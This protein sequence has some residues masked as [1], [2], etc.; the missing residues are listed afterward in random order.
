MGGRRRIMRGLGMCCRARRS[1]PAQYAGDRI[2]GYHLVPRWGTGRGGTPRQGRDDGSRWWNHR[3]GRRGEGG[4]TLCE[5]SG[6]VIGHVGD[7]PPNTPGIASPATIRC[8]C[9]AQEEVARPGRG[10]MMVAGGGTTG[11]GGEGRE[12]SRYARYRDVL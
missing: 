9:G 8:P 2:P 12:V 1:H 7:T 3:R 4:V 10:V 5:V 6:C 11:A